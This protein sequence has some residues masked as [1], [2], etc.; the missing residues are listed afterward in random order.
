MSLRSVHVGVL[1]LIVKIRGGTFFTNAI[2]CTVDY[3]EGCVRRVR[4]CASVRK[5]G[6]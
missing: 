1:R 4:R 3:H 5:V 2:G 6:G